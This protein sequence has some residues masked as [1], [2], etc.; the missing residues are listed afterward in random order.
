MELPRRKFLHLAAGSA[1]LSAVSPVARADA[2]PSRPVR[3]IVGFPPGGPT[4]LIARLMGQWLSTRLGQ[5][6]IVENRPG[7][8]SNIGAEI[9]VRA[10]PDGYTLLLISS[11]NAVNATL[12][13]NLPFNFI[14]DV[15]PVASIIRIPLV[16]VVNP[17]VPA[18][19]VPELITYAKANPGKLDFASPGN[20]TTAHLTGEMF[21]MMTGI[22]IVHVPYRGSAPALTDVLGGQVQALVDT[23]VTLIEH[24]KTGKLRALAVSSATRSDA[25]PDVSPM[26][27]FLPGFEAYAW[28]GIGAP[29]KAP[30]EI[31]DRLNFEINAGLADTTIKTRLTDLGAIMA[32]GS[33]QA[34]G[35]FIAAETEKWG[36]VIKSAGVKPE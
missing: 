29:A 36:K 10:L 1:A 34:F 21:K 25:L 3:F 8:S 5:P 19:T 13:D 27:D 33:P 24:I 17:S 2:Y 30:P 32:V 14:R 35:E 23:P 18:K 9:V 4:D 26:S 22:D 20:G 15:A 12:Y 7:N 11:A 6:F 28:F 31:I 16:L